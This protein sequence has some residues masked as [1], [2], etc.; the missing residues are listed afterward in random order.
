MRGGG[1]SG[2][3]RSEH[4]SRSSQNY[5]T[6]NFRRVRMNKFRVALLLA[7][8]MLLVAGLAFGQTTGSIVGTVAQ[9][10]TPLPGVTIEVRSA[11]LQGVR[12]DVTDAQGR[13]HFTQLP[14]GD[15]TL[16]A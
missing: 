2:D 8:S 4:R 1:H 15:Y 13:F 12:T 9:A 10:G 7:I 14:P 16:T 5:R 11:N 3:R 6:N